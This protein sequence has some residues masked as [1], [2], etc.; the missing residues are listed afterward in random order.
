MNRR[1]TKNHRVLGSVLVSLSLASSVIGQDPPPKMLA[2]AWNDLKGGSGHVDLM[3]TVS[4]WDFTGNPLETG[5]FAVLRIK[6]NRIYAV[7]PEEDIIRILRD[8]D[9][10][11][12]DI[13]NYNSPSQIVISGLEELINL[14]DTQLRLAKRAGKNRSQI[15]FDPKSAMASVA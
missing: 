14:A 10:G 5:R 6:G 7:C 4:P 12:I 11:G 8:N 15:A 3:N 1:T 9:L 2:V 13:A